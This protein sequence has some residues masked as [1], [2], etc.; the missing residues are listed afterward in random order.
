MQMTRKK[1]KILGEMKLKKRVKEL[2][3]EKRN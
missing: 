3:K 2:V 1:K